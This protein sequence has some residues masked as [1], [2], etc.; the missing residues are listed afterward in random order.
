MQMAKNAKRTTT[1]QK[2]LRG[3]EAHTVFSTGGGAEF[4]VTPLRRNNNNNNNNNNIIIIIIL[5][6]TEQNNVDLYYRG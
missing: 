5:L 1:K 3:A 6:L 4:E 2:M